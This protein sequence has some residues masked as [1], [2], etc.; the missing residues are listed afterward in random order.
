MEHLW[1]ENTPSLRVNADSKA[2]L[3]PPVWRCSGGMGTKRMVPVLYCTVLYCIREDRP[4]TRPLEGNLPL[5]SQDVD[6][7]L[8]LKDASSLRPSHL[9][10]ELELA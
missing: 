4:S 1:L 2:G 10:I 5:D 6:I 7:A 9:D 3:Q 8:G